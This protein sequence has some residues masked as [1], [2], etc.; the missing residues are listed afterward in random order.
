M[1]SAYIKLAGECSVFQCTPQTCWRT[2]SCLVHTTELLENKQLSSA[3][4]KLAGECTVVQCIPQTCLR[5]H[6]CLVHST[7]LLE[8]AQ[9]SSVYHKHTWSAT[10]L[11]Y[12]RKMAYQLFFSRAP[13]FGW[14]KR[15]LWVLDMKQFHTGANQALVLAVVD[16]QR[17]L[18]SGCTYTHTYN[19]WHTHINV[20]IK[21]IQQYIVQ[22]TAKPEE[23]H[24][25]PQVHYCFFQHILV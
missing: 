21:L 17:L 3:Y 24:I 8:N 2:H 19:I 25:A 7:N 10:I 1:S 22:P 5:T 4:H 15:A 9:L 18:Q 12:T 14:H 6:S 11:Y 23:L 13:A 20:D 16:G